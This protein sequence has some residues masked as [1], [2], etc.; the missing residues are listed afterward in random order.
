MSDKVL[1]DKLEYEN[2]KNFKEKW[3]SKNRANAKK[4]Y[5]RNK[6][7]VRDRTA[8]YNR[9]VYYEEKFGSLDAIPDDVLKFKVLR[10]HLAKEEHQNAPV[11]SS[12]LYEMEVQPGARRGSI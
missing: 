10:T 1:V 5:Q 11:P 7:R 9:L 4:F 6:D 8:R 12:E 3:T 2:L